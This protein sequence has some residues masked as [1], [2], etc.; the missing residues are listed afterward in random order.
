[1][2]TKWLDRRIAHPGPYLTL[3]TTEAQYHQAL[4]DCGVKAVDDWIKS[5]HADATVHYMNN[6]KGD[7]VA[8]VCIRVDASRTAIEIAGLLV[9]ESVHVWQDYCDRI[10]ER[11]PGREQEA[12]GIQ[13]ISQEILQA[14]SDGVNV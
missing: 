13:A 10:G 7:A 4:K 2:K 12:Y 1:M 5:A 14:Y 6:T 11:T 9:H 8:V 3:C